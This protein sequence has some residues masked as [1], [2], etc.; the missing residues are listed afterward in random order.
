MHHQYVVLFIVIDHTASS[1]DSTPAT[2]TIATVPGATTA[3][4]VH[5]YHLVPA[6]NFHDDENIFLTVL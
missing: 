2:T 5:P 1:T 4:N 3:G 6:M